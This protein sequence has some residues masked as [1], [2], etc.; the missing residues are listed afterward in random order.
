MNNKITKSI[1]IIITISLIITIIFTILLF[2]N[3]EVKI[4]NWGT[5]NII[6]MQ[7]QTLK[8][9]ACFGCSQKEFGKAMC[10]DPIKEM[11]EVSE[12][13]FRYCNNNF[14]VIE[15][16]DFIGIVGETC[17]ENIDCSLPME[18]AIQSNCPFLSMCID[19]KCSVVCPIY[20]YD[21][22]SQVNQNHNFTCNI[23]NQCNCTERGNISLY[24]KCINNKCF[25]V[26]KK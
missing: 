1:G 7:H 20:Y 13:R 23:D 24:C 17:N 18:Y 6:L 2:T 14:E 12:T 25:S 3:N 5:D 26:E 11:K 4:K 19:S 15:D 9:Y 8:T 16:K 21:I 22:N 10:I